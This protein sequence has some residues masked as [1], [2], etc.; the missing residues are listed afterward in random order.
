MKATIET[1]TTPQ[2]MRELMGLDAMAQNMGGPT[3]KKE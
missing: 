3:S 2:E 1:D